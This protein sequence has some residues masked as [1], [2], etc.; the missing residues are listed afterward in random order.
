[1]QLLSAIYWTNQQS[2]TYNES[3]LAV[4]VRIECEILEIN[5][6]NFELKLQVYFRTIMSI[7]PISV[8]EG[9]LGSEP[10]RA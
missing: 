2:F 7:I 5:Y 1:M 8:K 3:S 6:F 10:F 4:K 9:R